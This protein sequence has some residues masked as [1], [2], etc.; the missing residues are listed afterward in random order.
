MD[1]LLCARVINNCVLEWSACGRHWQ[2]VRL[3][4]SSSAAGLMW[5][6]DTNIRAEAQTGSSLL[7]SAVHQ[8]TRTHC[9]NECAVNHATTVQRTTIYTWLHH[10]VTSRSRCDLVGP[11]DR[12]ILD[13]PL[14]EERRTEAKAV[15]GARMWD[16]R[17]NTKP[18]SVYDT[19]FGFGYLCAAQYSTVQYSMLHRAYRNEYALLIV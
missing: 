18:R 2:Y 4:V 19:H 13:A 7:S 9:M 3:F 1:G 11:W 5:I 15:F 6:L 14:W 12:C 17:I 10:Y 8:S 16:P